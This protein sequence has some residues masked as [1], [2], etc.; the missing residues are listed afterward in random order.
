MNLDSIVRDDEM[1]PQLNLVLVSLVVTNFACGL[2]L[3]FHSHKTF[4]QNI[5]CEPSFLL[6]A[7]CSVV[8]PVPD[9]T[10]T[11]TASPQIRGNLNREWHDGQ[12]ANENSRQGH[13]D[14]VDQAPSDQETFDAS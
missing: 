10:A 13:Q 6:W 4:F 11:V 14:R 1:K 9:Q 3:S 8:N 12:Q 5:L 7:R 2:N